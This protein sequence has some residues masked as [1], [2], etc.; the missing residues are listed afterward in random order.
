MYRKTM[1]TVSVVLA[2]RDCVAGRCHSAAA[3]NA[4]GCA[5]LRECSVARYPSPRNS[6]TP[7]AAAGASPA[8]GGISAT[9]PGPRMPGANKT[10]YSTLVGHP[11]LF[12]PTGLK[13]I[14]APELL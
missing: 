10:L 13:S 4:I 14:Y 6:A 3:M 1:Y 7:P 2:A 12:T 8:G 11:T 5:R 9:S